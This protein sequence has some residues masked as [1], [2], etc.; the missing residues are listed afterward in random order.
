MMKLNGLQMKIYYFVHFLHFM[1][2]YLITATI[3]VASGLVFKLDF[4]TEASPGIYVILLVLWGFAM[5]A[6]S[7]LFSVFFS[8]TRNALVFTFMIVLCGVIINLA[9]TIIFDK[10]PILYLTWPPFAF[11]RALNLI[12]IAST[13]ID[14]PNYS[15]SSLTIDNDIS[16]IMITLAIEFICLI[17]LFSYFVQVWPSSYGVG[18]PWYFPFSSL[19][20]SDSS[21]R[22]QNRSASE[23][24]MVNMRPVSDSFA[25]EDMYVRQERDRINAKKYPRNCPIVIDNVEKVY[26][27]GKR[28]IRNISLAIE[29]GSVFGL[30]G[31]NGAGKTT[32]VSVLTGVY[33]MSAGSAAIAG[34]NVKT[35]TDSIFNVIGVCPQYDILWDSLTVFVSNMKALTP[36]STYI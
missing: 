23:I 4:F 17:L 2:L 9:A 28:A 3:F 20:H 30:L 25:N 26:P 24:P 7:L 19:F 18:K 16:I 35:E 36:D 21:N 5:T 34:F 11:Y 12:N 29:K 10:T 31:S 14:I 13:D 1:F 32:L 27:D 6:L 15:F 22:E 8:K 33:P